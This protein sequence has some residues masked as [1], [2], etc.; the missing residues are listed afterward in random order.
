M[1]NANNAA[2]AYINLSDIGTITAS[3][4]IAL[5]PPA[6]LQN[7]HVARKWRGR[8]GD[9]ETLVID[10]LSVQLVD[11]VLLRGLNLTAAGVT[12]LRVSA[13]DTSGQA[14]EL[15][16][17]ASAVGRVDPAYQTLLFLLPSPVL[18]RYLRIDLTETDAAYV[19]AGRLFVGFRHQFGINFSYG[20]SEQWVDRSRETESR[21]GQDY[22]DPDVS[23]RVWSLSFEFL[24]GADK[25][26][27]IVELDRLN[28]I[29]TDFLM[30]ADPSN[31][32]L[33]KSSMWGRRKEV[34][35]I[36]QPIGFIDDGG[37]FSK[38]F[39]IYERL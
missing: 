33:G 2:I 3:S 1:P 39:T 8:N 36:F 6:T 22:I 4:S 30:I 5:A 34:S 38:A 10:L 37:M 13:V 19:E 16:D 32:N 28:G 27:I 31:S 9:T 29:R 17:S 14:G 35:P 18:A 20:W 26:S 25:D 7:P 12:R 24:S 11:T 21:G 15:Y 23:R